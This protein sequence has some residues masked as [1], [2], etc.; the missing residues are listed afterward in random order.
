[1][2]RSPQETHT[3]VHLKS[4]YL[5]GPLIIPLVKYLWKGCVNGAK[6]GEVGWLEEVLA[7]GLAEV[8]AGTD[9]VSG[10]RR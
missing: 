5:V 6:L 1:M 7:V 10:H 3:T 4:R 9:V 8:L 2:K